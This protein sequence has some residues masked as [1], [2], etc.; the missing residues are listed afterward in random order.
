MKQNSVFVRLLNVIAII[1]FTILFMPPLIAQTSEVNIHYLGHSSFIIYFDNGLSVLTDYGTSNAFGLTSPIY[2][3]GN[4]TPDII[5][6]SHKHDDHYNA[7]RMPDSVKYILT[8]FDTLS[9]SGL[10]IKP[11]RTGEAGVGAK[12]NSSFVFQYKGITLIHLGD[13]HANIINIGSEYN[14]NMLKQIFPEKIDLLLMTIQGVS[15]FI[16]AAEE[17][18]DFLHPR[19]VI[20]IHYWTKEYKAEFLS[21]LESQNYNAGKSYKIDRHKGAKFNLSTSDTSSKTIEVISLEPAAFSHFNSPDIRFNSLELMESPGNNNGRA[22]AGE[23]ISLVVSLENFW[24]DAA[25]VSA[26]LRENDP[27]VQII[28]PVANFSAIEKDKIQ[29]NTACPYTFSVSPSSIAHY[30][31][32]YLDI[33]AAGGYVTVDSFT[34]IIGTPTILLIDDDGGNGYET[35]YANVLIPEIWDVSMKGCPSLP[36]LQQYASVIWSTG[37]DRDISLTGEEQSLLAEFLNR[38][39]RLLLCGQNIS[40]DLGKNSSP[41]DSLFLANYLHAKF[42]SDSTSATVVVGVTGDPISS[43]LMMSLAKTVVGEGDRSSPDIISA[44]MPEELIFKYVP[45]MAGAG[46]KYENKSTGARLV[47]LAFGIEKIVGPK[48]TTA[49]ELTGKILTWLSGMTASDDEL[50]RPLLPSNYSLDQ[51]FPNPF[52]PRT[53]IQYSLPQACF[54]SLKIYN[55]LGEKL[56]T[57][58]EQQQAAG[59]YRIGFSGNGFPSGVYLYQLQAGNFIATKKCVIVR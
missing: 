15:G 45:G 4:L 17:F 31:T 40:Y 54:V 50:L 26:M 38:G 29:S 32:F 52:N 51:N 49:T 25:N 19:K 42:I 30:H 48:A 56:A 18:I 57:L 37:D 7:A 43:G 20:P 21:Y 47:Y 27:D 22:D 3:I 10:T 44:I 55:L 9:L 14:R 24:I 39:G 46:I 53:T 41:G 12:D 34:I 16:P 58:V 59:A 5:T 6:Y 11:I 8:E 1:F 35:C 23:S 13:A 2:S 36:L 28:N 33:A